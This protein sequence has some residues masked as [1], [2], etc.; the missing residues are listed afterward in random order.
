MRS[1]KITKYRCYIPILLLLIL[2]ACSSG[3]KLEME[4][5]DSVYTPLG[6]NEEKKDYFEL[7]KE[8][9]RWLNTKYRNRG[10]DYNGVDCSGMVFSIYHKVYGKIL[11]RSAV[12]IYKSNCKQVKKSDLK[13]GDLVFFNT[14]GK[15]LAGINHVGIYLKNSKFIHASTSRGVMISSLNEK[16]IEK[17]WVC[18]GRIK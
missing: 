10:T 14:S 7:Y 5:R 12:N 1:N 8:A 9:S 4:N 15:R 16:Y 17:S 18:G 2:T 6:I 3:R 11:E 13:E